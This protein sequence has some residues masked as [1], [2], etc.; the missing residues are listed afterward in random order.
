MQEAGLPVYVFS[1]TEDGED[2]ME[3][4]L[5]DGYFKDGEY[6]YCDMLE[7]LRSVKESVVNGDVPIPKEM[8]EALERIHDE[9]CSDFRSIRPGIQQALCHPAFVVQP[10]SEVN[11]VN[12]YGDDYPPSCFEP[13]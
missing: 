10:I 1:W 7:T 11:E 13:A 6:V 2:H 9:V 3:C 4:Q 8:Q 5:P 12:P